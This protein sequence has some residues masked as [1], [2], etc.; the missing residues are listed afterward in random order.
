MV[1]KNNKLQKPLKINHF[2][3]T[4]LVQ[5]RRFVYILITR[6]LTFDSNFDSNDC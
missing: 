5:P 2:L 6:H 4:G 3:Y 1:K